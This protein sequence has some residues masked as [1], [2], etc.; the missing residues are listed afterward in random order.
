MNY[1][2]VREE[3]SPEELDSF[4]DLAGI[5]LFFVALLCFVFGFIFAAAK[6][7]SAVANMAMNYEIP[8]AKD[9]AEST[10]EEEVCE[11][12]KPLGKCEVLYEYSEEHKK[13]ELIFQNYLPGG[14]MIIEEDKPRHYNVKL[15]Y[16]LGEGKEEVPG[17]KVPR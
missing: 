17:N 3:E 13:G 8:V 4:W 7:S 10:T 6:V 14:K 12:F 15:V 2:H 5:L 11:P 1:V 9:M 16:S